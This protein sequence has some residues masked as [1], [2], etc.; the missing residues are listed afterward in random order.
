MGSGASTVGITFR[1]EK[2]GPDFD[3]AVRIEP[4]PMSSMNNLWRAYGNFDV[5]AGSFSFYTELKVKNDAISGYV[6]PLFQDINVYDS[7]QDKKKGFFHKIY[8]GLLGG[9]SWLLE[10]R[11]NDQV[12]TVTTVSGRLENP[13][14]NIWETLVGLV[15]N[16]FFKAILPGFD[17]TVGALGKD[18]KSQQAQ[19]ITESPKEPKK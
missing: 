8:E 17:R 10:N 12:A 18:E 16:A 1:P 13:Q 6:K 19:A 9:I 7:R 11:S 15:Q 14:T 5:V 4:T 3:L 2:H